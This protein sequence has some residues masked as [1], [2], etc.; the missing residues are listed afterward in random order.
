MDRFVNIFVLSPKEDTQKDAALVFVVSG[1][2]VVSQRAANKNDDVQMFQAYPGELVGGLAV[3]TGEPSF[4]TV[5]SR[6]TACVAML[7]KT[8]FYT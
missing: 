1:T 8:T 6:H 5:R 4:F 7:S 3:L 2:L